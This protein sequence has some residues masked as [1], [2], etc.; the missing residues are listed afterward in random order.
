MILIGKFNKSTQW[1]NKEDEMFMGA[2]EDG[3]WWW[4]TNSPYQTKTPPFCAAL[5]RLSHAIHRFFCV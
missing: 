2:A 1:W 5:G 4:A 3:D